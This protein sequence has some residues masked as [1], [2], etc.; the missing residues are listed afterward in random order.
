MENSADED[1]RNAPATFLTLTGVLFSIVNFNIFRCDKF[2]F[3]N[4]IR[5][6]ILV[7]SHTFCIIFVEFLE[8]SKK[9]WNYAHCLGLENI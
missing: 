3:K 7:S 2:H 8:N 6:L 4:N 1:S 9:L 5:I